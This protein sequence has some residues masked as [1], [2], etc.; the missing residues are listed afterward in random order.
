LQDGQGS[1]R[2]LADS[3]GSLTDTY[4]YTAFG[5]I[6]SQTGSTQNSY[7][8]TGQQYDDATG[9]Y[10]L[11]ARYYNPALGRFLSQDT[12]P[13]NFGNPI[14]LNRYGYA[15]GNPVNYGDPSGNEAMVSS[16]SLNFQSVKTSAPL[17]GVSA[18]VTSAIL[19]TS[20]WLI[21]GGGLLI[22]LVT[23][24]IIAEAVAGDVLVNT[25]SI[26]QGQYTQAKNAEDAL[27]LITAAVAALAARESGLQI[28]YR[29]TTL[30][31]AILEQ[32]NRA[33]RY[34]GK[35]N[36]LWVSETVMMAIWWAEFNTISENK[37]MA[38]ISVYAIPQIIWDTQR[39]GPSAPIWTR[40][41]NDN[42]ICSELDPELLGPIVVAI[43]RAELR[44]IR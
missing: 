43:P 15:R 22:L 33:M 16:A 30:D 32:N 38:A 35:D 24:D 7:L 6:Y 11:R 40:G 5:E 23:G 42:G 31:T 21:F 34:D 20:A 14:E 18:A 39:G 2:S 4:S 9:L 19:L 1:T 17:I 37:D 41:P 25:P 27:K 28:V 10:N 36:R 26:N 8:Y 3:S 13:V 29:G 44:K 12:Y